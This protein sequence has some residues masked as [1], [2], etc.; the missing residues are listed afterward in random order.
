MRRVDAMMAAIGAAV[1]PLVDAAVAAV[2]GG[3]GAGDVC[4]DGS[5]VMQLI[6]TDRCFLSVIWP[7]LYFFWMFVACIHWI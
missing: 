4:E 2:G 5:L 7:L 6:G 1:R 3:G